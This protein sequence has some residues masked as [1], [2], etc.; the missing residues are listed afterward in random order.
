MAF[1]KIVDEEESFEI[2]FGDSV[3][4]CRRMDR[5]AFRRIQKRH[6]QERFRRGVRQE[7]ADDA[8][9]DAEV[10]D[11]CIREWRGVVHPKTG[12]EVACTK[13]NKGRLPASVVNEVVAQCVDSDGTEMGEGEGAGGGGGERPTGAGTSSDT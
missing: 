7:V 3:L 10:L 8:A 5:G 9:I 4:V 2:K 6:T 11:Y 13:E 1:I 12:E